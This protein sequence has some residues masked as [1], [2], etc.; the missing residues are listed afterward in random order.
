MT[1]TRQV[2]A[3]VR[4]Q[5]AELAARAAAKGRPLRPVPALQLRNSPGSESVAGPANGTVRPRVELSAELAAGEP[6]TREF[7]IGHE[8]AHLL[9]RQEGRVATAYVMWMVTALWLVGACALAAAA[10]PERVGSG[11]LVFGLWFGGLTA[12]LGGLVLLMAS[13]RRE[14][15]RTDA[16]AWE[17]F[18]VVVTD[19]DERRLLRVEGKARFLPTFL[20]THPHPQARLAAGRRRLQHRSPTPDTDGGGINPE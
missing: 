16:T 19:P 10:Y 9:R 7:T 20:R 5:Y 18:G 13:I 11:I 17:V 3:D 8:L 15:S 2:P 14:E 4:A 6:A 1:Q 12:L